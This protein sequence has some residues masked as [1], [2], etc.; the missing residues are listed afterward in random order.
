VDGVLPPGDE[1]AGCGAGRLGGEAA[2]RISL[3]NGGTSSHPFTA[4]VLFIATNGTLIS[5]TAIVRSH[6]G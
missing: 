2:Q 5:K 6:S 4:N 1:H 3:R